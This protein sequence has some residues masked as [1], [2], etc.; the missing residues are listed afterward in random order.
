V[1]SRYLD[2]EGRAHWL[3]RAPHS[4]LNL[5]LAGLGPDLAQA[6]AWLA[7][8][9]EQ[10]AQRL[11]TAPP[12][13]ELAGMTLALP[14]RPGK[15]LALGRNFAAHA[16]EMGAEPSLEDML[17]FNKLPEICVASG[18]DMV[19][20]SWMT[21]RVDPEAE[22]VLLLAQPLRNAS[23]Q[24]AQAAIAAFT[25]GNDLTARA[26]QAGDKQKAWPWLRSKNMAGFG[27]YGPGWLPADLLGDW[28]QLRLQGLVNGEVRQEAQLCDMLY[29][30]ARA[31]SELSR[32]LPLSAGDM[33]FLGTPS[34]VQ[35]LEPLDL[36]QVRVL[37]SNK[38]TPLGVLENRFV[39]G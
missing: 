9:P 30:P 16:L 4:W 6:A 29:T 12:R 32:W 5:S 11:E 35:A 25:L 18:Q 7:S 10:R 26:V 17:W 20:P 36:M 27:S 33:V 37:D 14:G 19:A 34:G 38:A 1:L 3:W 21:E 8:G 28:R 24:E 39:R 22:L 23:E 31:L 2:L 15:I 13:A